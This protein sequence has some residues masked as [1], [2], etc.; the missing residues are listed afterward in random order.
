M[1]TADT[2]HD[3]RTVVLNLPYEDGTTLDMSLTVG[4]HQELG[5]WAD[6]E[7]LTVEEAAIFFLRKGVAA[8]MNEMRSAGSSVQGDLDG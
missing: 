8:V 1:N 4:E 2:G 5:A 3:E 6:A 7:G